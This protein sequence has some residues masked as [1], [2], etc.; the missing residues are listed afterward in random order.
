MLLQSGIAFLAMCT[1]PPIDGSPEDEPARVHFA[2]TSIAEPVSRLAVP[3]GAIDTDGDGIPDD[4]ELTGVPDEALLDFPAYGADPD[5][6]DVFV[7]ADWVGCNPLTEFCGPNN[8]L[9]FYQVTSRVAAEWASFYQPDFAIHIDNGVDPTDPAL[10]SVHGAWGGAHRLPPGPQECNA[11]SLGPRYGYFHRSSHIGYGGGG[12]GRTR[13]YCFAADSGHGSVSAHELGHNLGLS[14]GGSP[15]TYAVNCKP[16]YRSPMNYGYLYDTSVTQFSRGERD[17]PLNGEYMDESAG[18][19]TM[20]QAALDSLQNSIWALSV[21]ENGAID[22]NRNG[23]FETEPVR[24]AVTWGTAS[25]EQSFSHSD[26]FV[27]AREPTLVWLPGAGAMV[28]RLYALVRDDESGVPGYRYMTSIDCDFGNPG[29][30]C[31]DWQ[32]GGDDPAT[33]IPGALAGASAVAGLGWVEGDVRRLLIVYSDEQGV[34]YR[35]VLRVDETGAETWTAPAAVA[36]GS[37]VTDGSPALVQDPEDER[38]ALLIA[39]EGDRLVAWSGQLES[40]GTT[41]EF[42]SPNEQRWADGAP[43]MPCFGV[44]ATSGYQADMPVRGIYALIPSGPFCRLEFARL[45]G[46]AEAGVWTRLTDSMW[47]DYEPPIVGN[48]PGLAY[49]PYTSN[50]AG[51]P[52]GDPENGRFYIAYVYFPES[53]AVIAMTEGNDL[54]PEAES[55]RMDLKYG[56]YMRNVWATVEGGVTLFHDERY[57]AN[58]RGMWTYAYGDTYFNPFADGIIDV[59]MY[60]DDDY[61]V[62]RE[63]IACSLT[64]SCP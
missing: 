13:G 14:H 31:T 3:G 51:E 29:L 17:F 15:T 49:V 55:R 26:G 47:P 12:Q 52:V 27:H 32:P 10:A 39:P 63:N 61:A 60:D 43:I 7:Q 53:P 1:L 8:S 9:D 46:D 36:G 41:F 58:L 4:A 48:R 45:E 56:G 22:W 25:C 2:E 24:A 50:V 16:H 37:A 18:F 38:S 35:Q 20:D 34:L 11:S 59:D 64:L 33:P 5:V 42:S 21:H 44:A 54:R 23:V 57:D 28:P 30:S 40:G 62:M 19:G 6:P